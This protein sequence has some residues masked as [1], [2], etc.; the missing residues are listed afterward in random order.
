VKTGR[1]WKQ[2]RASVTLQSRNRSNKYRP[3][4]TDPGSAPPAGTRQKIWVGGY[5]KKDGTKVPG[6]FRENRYYL[7]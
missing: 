4:P 2:E 3:R 5:T 1:A 6:Y 7:R